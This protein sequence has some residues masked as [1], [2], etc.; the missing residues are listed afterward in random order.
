VPG[1]TASPPSSS[2]PTTAFAPR[3]LFPI[4]HAI[5]TPSPSRGLWSTCIRA[6]PSAAFSSTASNV[7]HARPSCTPTRSRPELAQREH[8]H[9]LHVAALHVVA[10]LV[11][12]L[13]SSSSFL[14]CRTRASLRP[15]RIAGP[16]AAVLAKVLPCAASLPSV[17]VGPEPLRLT[18]IRARPNRTRP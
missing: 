4:R 6:V 1:C 2:R 14:C 8:C 3:L 11:N 16:S 17:R 9:A 10:L 18:S 7:H 12:A 5:L 13:H 15:Y